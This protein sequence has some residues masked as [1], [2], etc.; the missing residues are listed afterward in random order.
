[1]R[2]PKGAKILPNRRAGAQMSELTVANYLGLLLDD[3][4]D[5]QLIEGLRESLRG[6]A[7]ANEGQDPLRL[8]EAARGGH[9]RRGE[10]LAASWLIELECELVIDDPEFQKVLVKELGRLRRDELMDDRGALCAYEKLGGLESDDPEVLQAVDQIH[11]L[12]EKWRE[13]ADRFIEEARDAADPRLK[14]SLLTRAASLMWQYGGNDLCEE[15]DAIFDEALAADPS[16]MRTARQY[17]LSLRERGRWEDVVSVFMRAAKAARTRDEKASAWLQAARVQR[18]SLDDAEGA[19]DAYRK[20]LELTPTDQEALEALVQH[21]TDLEAWDEL[22]SMY[23][24]A[25]RSRQKLEDEKGMLLQLA[26]VHWKFRR[27]SDAAEPFFAR[28]RKI[29]AAHPGMLQFYRE[30][31]GD[32]DPSGRLLT[33]IGDALRTT[34]DS[35]HQLQLAR[36]LGLR[37][38]KADRPE[39]ALE[40][41]KMVERLAPGDLDARTALQQLYQS[42]GK[43]NALSESIRGEIEALSSDANEQKIRLLRDLVPIYRDA[44]K[45]DSMLIQVYGEILALS[46]YDGEALTALG[47]LYEDAGRWNE[48]IQV[49]ERQAELAA[50]LPDKVRLYLR[51]AHL[52]LDRFANLNQAVGPLERVVRL[53]PDHA[54]ALAQ[55]KDIYTRKRKWEALFGVLGREAELET[56]PAARLEKKIEMAELCSERLHHNGAAIALWKEILDEHPESERGLDT[57]ESLAEREK[58][59]DTLVEALR[60]RAEAS[61][62]ESVRRELLQR[63]GM[64]LMERLAKP[65]EA[66]EAWEAVLSLDPQNSRVRRMLRDAY[67]SQGDWV[68]LQALYERYDDWS[69]LAEVLS[70]TA[71][72]VDEPATITTLSLRAAEIYRDRLDDPSRAARCYER[73]LRADP[74]NVEAATG[75]LP[76]YERDRKWSEYVRMLEIVVAH[77][78]PDEDV[79]SS[80][81]RLGSLRSACLHRLRDPEASLGWATRAYLLAPGEPEV[82]AGLEESAEAAGAHADLVALFRDRLENSALDQA[83][84]LDLQRRI[85]AIAGERLGESEESIRQLEAI[86]RVEPDDAE[87]MAVLDRLY[88]AVRRFAD[89][90]ALYERRLEKATD[91]AERW[92]LLNEVAQVEEE[93]LGDLP[94]AA[95]RHWQILES[96]PHD[97][98]ALLAVE[99]LSQQLK[100]WDRLDAA[101]ARRLQ[102]KMSDED[103]LSVYLQLAD[104]R[105]IHL[106][107]AA[108]ALECYRSALDLDGRNEVAIA[109]LEALSAEGGGVGVEAIDLLEPAYAKRGHFDRLAGLLHK[110]LEQAEGAEERRVLQLR[111]ADLA[112]SELGDARGAYQAVESAFLDDPTDLDLFERLGGVAE[113]ADMH[114]A[115]ARA[116]SKAVDGAAAGSDIELTLCRRAAELFDVMLGLP[117][118]AARFH[119]RV[120]EREPGDT[121]AFTA[122]KQLY[123]KQEEWDDLRALYQQRIEATTDATT[124]LDL[125]LQLCFLFEEILDEP[126]QAI[127]SYEEAVELDPT[128]TPSRRAL[129]RL[130]ARLGRWSELSELLQRDL[131]EAEGQEAVD[132]AY[133]LATIYETRLDRFVDAVDHYERVL[134]SSPT[135]LRAQ[136]GLQRLMEKRDQRQRVAAILQPIFESQGAWGELAKVLEVQLEDLTEPASRAAHLSRL[137]ELSEIKLRDDGLAFAAYARAVREDVADGSARADLARLASKLDRHPERAE[138]LESGLDA[139]GDDFVRTEV[140][141]ELA[142]LWDVSAPDPERAERAYQQLIRFERD[143][144]DIVL[145]ASRALERLHRAGGRHGDLAQDLRRQIRFEED[146]S[147]R[148]ELFPMLAELLETELGDPEAAIE[149]HEQRLELDPTQTEALSALER[150]YEQQG[151]WEP[152]VGVL[153]RKVELS[154]DEHDQL[155]LCRRIAETYEQKLGSI[156]RAVDSY[157]DVISRFGSDDSS[158]RALSRL[159]RQTER[160]HELLDVAEIRA[161]AAADPEERIAHRFEAAELMRTRTAE[162]ERAFSAYGEI[163]VDSPGHG[164]TLQA[165]EEMTTGADRPLR[166]AA[167]NTLFEQYQSDGRHADQIRMLEVIAAGDEPIER[168]RALLR[169]AE[170]SETGREDIDAAFVFTGRALRDGVDLDDLERVLAE[171]GRQ[172]DTTGR[173]SEQVATLATIAPELLDAELRTKVRMQAARVAMEHLGDADFARAQYQRVLEEQPDHR[174]ALDALLTLVEEVGATRELAELLRRKIELSDDPEERA[175]LLVRQAHLF[176]S[177]LDDPDSAIEALDQALSENEHPLAY[178]GL[179]RLYRRT[180]QWDALA[181]L[182][183]REID[184]RVGDPAAVRYELGEICLQRLDEPWRAIDQFREALSQSPEHEPTVRALESLVERSEYRGAAA[185]LL[186]PLYLRRMEWDKVTR[187]LEARLEGETNPAQRLELLRHLGDVQESHLED[188]DGALETYGR[189]FSEDPHDEHSKE[190]LT[191]LAR[192]LGRWDRLAAI[193]DKTLRAVEVDDG[194]T[195]ALA[196]TTAKLYDERLE[197]LD[198]AGYFYQRALTYDPSHKEA[199][200]ALASVYARSA[201]WDALLELDRERE[202]FSDSDAERVAIL[203][204]IAR[205]EVDELGLSEDAIITFRRIVEVDPKDKEAIRRLDELLE[206]AERWEDLAAHVEFQIDN[207]PDGRTGLE[208]R[209]RLGS[210]TESKLQNPASALDIF[211]DILADRPDYEPALQ[212]VSRWVSDADHGPRAVDILEPIHRQADD[213]KAL[214]E[215]L[216]SKAEQGTDSFERAEIWREIAQIRE[217]RG[218]DAESA[219][220]AWGRAWVAEPAD[221]TT[222]AEVYRLAAS[223]RCWEAYIETCERAVSATEEPALRGSILRSVAETRDQELG[224]PRGAID[225]HRRVFEADPD[226]EESLDQLEGLQ[227]MVGDWQGLAWVYERKLDRAHDAEARAQLL[228]RLGALYEEQLSDPERAVSYFEQATGESPDDPDAYVALDRLFASVNDSERLAGVLERRM[229]IEIDPEVVVE[230]GLRLAELYE[231]Q[232]GRP[233]AACDALRAVVEADPEHRGAL[234][235]L[236]RLYERQAQWPEL[237]DVLRQRADAA[238]H[239]SERVLLTHQLGNVLERELDDEL[240]AI[241]VYGQV[242]RIDPTHEPSVRALLRITKLDDY[243]EDAAAVVEPHLRAQAR[244]NDL[245]T[246]LRLRA[247]AMTDPHQKAEQLV[248]LADV[249]EQGRQDPNAALDALLQSIGERADDDEIL[250]RAEQLARSLQRWSDLIDVLFT[251]ASAN[252]DADRGAALYRRVARICEEDLR[253]LSRAIEAHERA[254][255]LLG[256]EP[257][258]LEAL[259]RLLQATGQWERLHDVISRRLDLQDAD[260]PTLLLRQGRLRASHLGDFEGALGAYQRAMEQDPGRDDALIAVRGLAQK[261][262]VAGNALALLEEYYRGAGDLEQVV[263]LYDQRVELA[264]TDADRVALLTE[265]ATIWEEE[266]GRL[267]QALAVTR[268]AVRIDPRDRLLIDSLER[269]AELSGGWAEL[270]GL[271]DDIAARGDLDRRELYEL[272]LR[273]A[274][275]ARDRMGD[276]TRAERALNE[277]LQIDPEPVEAYE[278]LAALLRQQ[279]RAADLVTML[280][281][282]ADV[283]PSPDQRVALLREAAERAREELSHGELAADCYQALIAIEHDDMEAL[284]ALCEIRSGQSRWNEVVG[285]LERQL[286]VAADDQRASIARSM[287]EVYRDRLND[288]RAAISAYERALD[289]DE[290]DASAM[291]ALEGLYRDHDRLEALRALLERRAE[292]A[293]GPE[294][295]AFQLRLAQLYEHSFR[296]QHAAI[297]MFQRVLEVDPE[298]DTAQADL[299]RLFEATGAWDDLIALL[300]SRLGLESEESQ[301]RLL[302]RIGHIHDAKR[303]DTDAAIAAFQRIHEDLGADERSLQALA[304]LYER[305]QS[306]TQ[307]ADVLERLAGH[308]EGTEAIDLFHRVADL[309]EQHIGDAEQTGRALR[310]AYGRFPQDRATVDRFKRHLEARGD[311]RALA[312]VLDAELQS[313]GSE[314]AELALLRQISD[315]YRDRLDDPAAAASYLER[316]VAL[317]PE[318]RGALVPLCDLYMAAG[319]QQDAVPILR[320]II[321]SFG[322]QRGKELALHHHRLGQALAAAGDTA[323]ALE[324]YD[325]AFKIDLTNV[326]ILRDLGKL[327]HATGD[328][329][330]AQKS[331]RA[332]LLQ[333]LEPDSGIHKADVYYYLGDIAAQQN[334]PRKA[335]TM[336]ERALAEDASHAQASEL[337][338]RL[339]G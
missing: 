309:W 157:R 57:L 72:Q 115:F 81:K 226:A 267:D 87:A 235:G 152:L 2:S 151:R 50:E 43:W 292:R 331:F 197:E 84:R 185:E 101:L 306:W 296:D 154:T 304:A 284:C 193:F 137:G 210:L 268:E 227:V 189:L 148:D 211:E 194:D 295:T 242:L 167:A 170:I 297:T 207:A 85:A 64:L 113:A 324:A 60:M 327:T 117:E 52:W 102:S 82:V 217:G 17:A 11:Q 173:F 140:L 320:R 100:Q 70:Q 209:Q 188:L 69:G 293:T 225:T 221:E 116:L 199:G 287:G 220:D 63:I 332:L 271:V 135:H 266:L 329:D 305:K 339:K 171:Y 15:A 164:P 246:L 47:A 103:R 79:A 253:D 109:G 301:R 200:R 262:E 133:E 260:R 45:L 183:E 38:Q 168:V 228:N 288:P 56:E 46:P 37:A 187:I 259:D 192:S 275:W 160:W 323:G 337:L 300:S 128:H 67:V 161:E 230:L 3:P 65:A 250:D 35:E 274:A 4:Y 62:S 278:Q 240:S 31:I 10:F 71:E 44:L 248:A 129:Q 18:R 308:V 90:R 252:L 303:D 127:A 318:N 76:M 6:P 334:D 130:Y 256:D 111:L 29:D 141:L 280:R 279:G 153:E 40:A 74:Q 112:G 270:D 181:T 41:W 239:E 319:R 78:A 169:A 186:E 136:E 166:F 180:R 134:E 336:L 118:D 216:R 23:E 258:T 106:G 142:E 159:Y 25:L 92:V 281:A 146:E 204:E 291:D 98:D 261:P 144:P 307:V 203:H 286:E 122:L 42:S 163:L 59:W 32:D 315:V 222:R 322:R 290:H 143:N 328:L 75:L 231:A 73:A 276:S 93:Q 179:E 251:E 214:A 51:V 174:T 21:Y 213:W 131:D 244:W 294:L 215:V 326:A 272:R 83:E 219:F 30:Q 265:A 330:R 97:V 232:L 121:A 108:G 95:E 94:A 99:R 283:E 107:D 257:S 245:A 223:L 247:D 114:E 105:R 201:R 48:L 263:R 126:K 54:E 208:L 243:R 338:G 298:N 34:T 86:L 234:E 238:I 285:L 119:R 314:A 176:Q 333:K 27:D 277:A 145:K 255:L 53:Q 229:Q 39:R 104:L 335:I 20:V 155:V 149:V 147:R 162:T 202:S 1:M 249:H 19:A 36:E 310:A 233:D 49:L 269:L 195:A 13:V 139:V 150:L 16:H 68:S 212:A 7:P 325:A 175:E 191:R 77:A 196:L 28:L 89:L 55:L 198:R 91:S 241:A 205:I 172:A 224:D 24:S 289:L 254:R 14:T 236:S 156:D 125:L 5:F 237:V 58:D 165:L 206:A 132:L 302:E 299:E 321:E 124:K 61:S 178:E 158:L 182:Y 138:L 123:T 26:M 311:Y 184:Q 9:E 316:A 80:L 273:S 12:E 8:L 88:R 317:D 66:I 264:A 110:R 22:A 218:R 96:N 282:W 33:I 120:L 312:E 190:T 313:A 177:E